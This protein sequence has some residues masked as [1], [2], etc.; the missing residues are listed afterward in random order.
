MSKVKIIQIGATLRVI[1]D[2]S[3]FP[4]DKEV[5]LDIDGF[6]LSIE[7]AEYSF[8]FSDTIVLGLRGDKKIDITYTNSSYLDCFVLAGVLMKACKSVEEIDD[9]T[10]ENRT[11]FWFDFC[12]G[13]KGIHVQLV[14]KNSDLPIRGETNHIKLSDSTDRRRSKITICL[15]DMEIGESLH[16]PNCKD[17][18]FSLRSD[19]RDLMSI[20]S[21][22]NIVEEP[23]GI[24]CKASKNRF[25]YRGSA[26][27]LKNWPILAYK[28]PLI[29]KWTDQYHTS[30]QL[31]EVVIGG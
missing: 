23:D 19:I 24:R 13:E 18:L 20:I 11:P 10:F 8:L 25:T 26:R 21:S 1:A 28:Y 9:L 12:F 15:D 4:E 5:L 27:L 16:F 29:G 31:D 3:N 7:K 14:H 17:D 22:F 30:L 6:C 2:L